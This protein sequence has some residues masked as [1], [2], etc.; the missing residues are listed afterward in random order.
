MARPYS[1]DLRRKFLGA[2]D[3][4]KGTLAELAV[5]FGV[6]KDWAYK[7]SS[8]RKRTGCM[9]RVEQSRHGPASKV[10]RAQVKRLLEAQPDLLL[11]ELAVQLRLATGVQVGSPQLCRV[12][13]ELGLRRKKSLSTRASG[14]PRRAVSGVQRS[15]PKSA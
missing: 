14:T 7:I 8:A 5:Q 15:L 6:S 11:A 12:V 9:E 2:Y 13:K 4:G 10:D 3:S 1:N